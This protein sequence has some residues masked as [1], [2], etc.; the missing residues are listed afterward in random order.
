MP[1]MGHTTMDEKVT[2]FF[3]DKIKK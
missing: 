3:Q 2:T 1:P